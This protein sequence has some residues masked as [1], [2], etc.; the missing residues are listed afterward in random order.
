MPNPECAYSFKDLYIAAFGKAPDRHVF[1]KFELASQSQKNEI[2]KQWAQKAGW[3]TVSRFGS[4]GAV[5]T[6][7]APKF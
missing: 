4:D 3:Q 7:F 2:V 6:A 1:S 5:Y